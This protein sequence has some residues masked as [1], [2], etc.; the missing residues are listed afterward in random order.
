M[1]FVVAPP[2]IPDRQIAAI[3]AIERMAEARRSTFEHRQW[4]KHHN[5]AKLGLKRRAVRSASIPQA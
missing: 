2:G 1:V 4:L 3:E 5:A